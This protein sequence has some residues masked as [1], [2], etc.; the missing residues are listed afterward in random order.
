MAFKIGTYLSLEDGQST[1]RRE[2]TCEK[3]LRYV[4]YFISLK[5]FSLKVRDFEFAKNVPFLN[6]N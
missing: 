2:E 5:C 6:L 1:P 4:E 3:Y